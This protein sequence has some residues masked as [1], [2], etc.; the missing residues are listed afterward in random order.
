MNKCV[1]SDTAA[2]TTSLV[3]L[4]G[5]TRARMVTALR[6]ESLAVSD[7]AEALGLSEVAIRRHLSVLER[8]GLVGAQTVRRDGPGRPS[9][10]YTLT[11]RAQRLFPDRY[12]DLAN[13]L[14][15]YL[16]QVHGRRELL[17]FL[18]WRSTRQTEHYAEVGEVDATDLA[19]R[20]EHLAERLSEDGFLSEVR[21]TTDSHGRTVLELAQGSCAV[22]D[23][24]AEHPELCHFEAAMFQRLLGAPVSR[25]Q[26]IAGGASRCV[27]HIGAHRS[28]KTS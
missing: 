24:A 28:T 8:D 10:Y 4:L 9:A 14:L 6:G 17:A 16:E 5:D 26:T 25:Q 11:D 18:R 21:T 3:D 1:S 27:C 12:A 7:L 13:E 19:R 23:V 22:A 15:E 2:A 20:A